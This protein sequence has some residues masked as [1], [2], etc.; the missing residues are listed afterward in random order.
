MDRPTCPCPNRSDRTR[1]R[2]AAGRRRSPPELGF[3]RGAGTRAADTFGFGVVFSDATLGHLA[4]ADP[5]THA[6]ITA[7]FARWSDIEIHG[8]GEVMRSTGH[9]F[10]GIER[11]ALLQIL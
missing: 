8:G 7:Q 2:R 5:E 9:G 1:S 4:D 6:Q 3:P 11:K 10:C